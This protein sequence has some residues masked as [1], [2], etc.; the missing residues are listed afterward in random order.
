[1][2]SFNLKLE[3]DQHIKNRNQIYQLYEKKGIQRLQ[4][5]Q[6]TLLSYVQQTNSKFQSKNEGSVLQELQSQ[7]EIE[8]LRVYSKNLEYQIDSLKELQDQAE[9]K[10]KELERIIKEHETKIIK[11]TKEISVKVQAEP[12]FQEQEISI[13]KPPQEICINKLKSLI[14]SIQILF[15]KKNKK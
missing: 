4:K 2:N 10:I 12:T 6:V 5:D 1:M 15:L 11:Q 14:I 13:D 7:D 8:K 9:L 3:L